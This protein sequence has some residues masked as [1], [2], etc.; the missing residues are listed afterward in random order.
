MKYSVDKQEKYAIFSLEDENLNSSIAPDLKSEFLMM[1][2]SG[3]MNLIFDLS[4]VKFVDSSG[5]S[6]ILTG[7]RLWQG[8]SFILTGVNSDSVKKLITI[9]KLDTILKIIPTLSESIDLVFMEE[10]ERELNEG[11]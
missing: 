2:N 1:R 8:G 10:M 9:S 7:N 11:D 5:L 4:A 6:A 3:V